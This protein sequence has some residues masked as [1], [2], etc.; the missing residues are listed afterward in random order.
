MDEAQLAR[1]K[2]CVAGLLSLLTTGL[3]QLYNGQARKAIVFYLL[4]VVLLT[5]YIIL[6]LEFPSLIVPGFVVVAVVSSYIVADAVVVALRTGE[7]YRLKKYNRLLV[8]IAVI[9]VFGVVIENGYSYLVRTYLVQAYKIP[10]GSM[11]PTLLV[12]DHILVDKFTDTSKSPIRG[13]I[14]V[15]VYPNDPRIDYIKRV[16]GLP[17][18][19]VEI[20]DKQ[21]YI[22]GEPYK[23]DYV[24]HRDKNMM[25]KEEGAR[26]NFGP[27]VVPGESYFVIGDN[28]DRSFDSRFW[29]FVSQDKIHGVAR[30]IYWSW[31]SNNSEVRWDRV[32]KAVK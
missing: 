21:L 5:V 14:A 26:D 20:R 7:N 9:A 10:A 29:G 23:E 24:V 32:S 15:F 31:D 17:G 11:E 30:V 28:R 4:P 22:N 1:R 8:Y 2:W 27:T 12:G 3:G 6:F 18:D 19:T 13:D 16:V 25:T